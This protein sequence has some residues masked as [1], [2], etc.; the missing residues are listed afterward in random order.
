MSMKIIPNDISSITV[1]SGS[2]E[3]FTDLVLVSSDTDDTKFYVKNIVI[4]NTGDENLTVTIKLNSNI[5]ISKTIT[6]DEYFNYTPEIIVTKDTPLSI[7]AGPL[8]NA[9]IS[10]LYIEK[11]KVSEV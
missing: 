5:I 9:D 7:S 8:A 11:I 6:K 4:S 10:I 1:E 2:Y 3:P